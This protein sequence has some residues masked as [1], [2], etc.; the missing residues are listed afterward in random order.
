MDKQGNIDMRNMFPQQFYQRWTNRETL[1]GN[2]MFPQQFYHRWTNRETLIG[3]I[4]FPQQFYHRWTN[5]ET[6]IG[7]IMF[8]KQFSRDGLTEENIDRKRNVSVF[9]SSLSLMP[10]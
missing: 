6:L 2:I 9:L 1:I 7:N 3:N 4:M 5:R 8:M 10:H